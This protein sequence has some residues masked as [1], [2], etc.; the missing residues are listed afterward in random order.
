L[1][2]VAL[3][4]GAVT[5][6]FGAAEDRQEQ[7]GQKGDDNDDDKKFDE[8]ECGAAGS[9]ASQEETGPERS[10]LEANEMGPTMRIL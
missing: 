3:A 6:L 9:N 4:S 2:E 10:D 1:A 5:L 7:R 8:G